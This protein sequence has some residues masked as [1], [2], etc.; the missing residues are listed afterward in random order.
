MCTAYGW[1]D[2]LAI[3]NDF[4]ADV[5][6]ALRNHVQAGRTGALKIF[7]E[8]VDWMRQLAQALRLAFQ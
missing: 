2:P 8:E 1:D 3:I 6:Q 5:Q 4:E 7:A